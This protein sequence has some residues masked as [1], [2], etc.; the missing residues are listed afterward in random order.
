MMIKEKYIIGIDGGGTKTEAI[1]F[2][3]EG[4]TLS[5]VDGTGTNLYVYKEDAAKSI[6]TLIEDLT[7]NVGI[8][9]SDISALGCS[10]AG[11]SD[12]N[13]R[14]LLLK[15]FDKLNITSNTLVLSDTESAY[16]LLCPSGQ[17][18]LVSIG[19]GIV[20][21]G[22][23]VEGISF[24]I[25]GKGYDKGDVGSG[26]WIGKETIKKIV[27]NQTALTVD[28]D[29]IEIYDIV[30]N[31]LGINDINSLESKLID[32]GD[33]VF[34]TALLAKDIITS[35]QN[36]NDISLSIIQ[37]G[38]RNVAE[39]ILFLID[40]L[41]ISKN[42]VIIAGNGSIIKNEFYRKSLN[43]SL[44][45]DINDIHWVFS[46]ISCAYSAGIMAA[47]YKNINVSINDIVKN[48]N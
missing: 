14:D 25:A 9:I 22:R 21:L 18:L 38:T 3:E 33:M 43:D 17:G 39:Y 46:N 23:D 41:K 16:N 15:Y 10:L 42:K 26:Y 32:E 40:D 24:K 19:T 7:K 28:D 6:L 27:L 12:L 37:E 45:F 4:K 48:I 47:K 11:I 8:N 35:A 5:R 2:N 36:G 31:Q 34:K 30:K 29:M 44:Q 20:C 13:S 1:L